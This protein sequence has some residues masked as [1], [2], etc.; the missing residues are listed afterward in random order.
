MAG[1]WNRLTTATDTLGEL[2][3]D[4]R[5]NRL[6]TER[7]TTASSPRL[8]TTEPPTSSTTS[9]SSTTDPSTPPRPKTKPLG[10]IPINYTIVKGDTL[11]NVAIRWRMSKRE[12]CDINHMHGGHHKLMHGQV[13]LVKPIAQLDLDAET[14]NRLQ[15]NSSST[16]SSSTSLN[17]NQPS[18]PIPSLFHQEP[19][20]ERVYFCTPNNHKIA[21]F[22]TMSYQLL[23]F[24]P[25]ADDP[26]V[27]NTKNGL[28]KF[29]FLMDVRDLIGSCEISH[30]ITGTTAT[31]AATTSPRESYE[32]D[33]NTNLVEVDD[34]ED[35]DDRTNASSHKGPMEWSMFQ[36]FWA[37]NGGGANGSLAR[38]RFYI[39]FMVPK[40]SIEQLLDTMRVYIEHHKLNG[41]NRSKH[42]P[43]LT[44]G[45][46]T[47]LRRSVSMSPEP[48]MGPRWLP[49]DNSAP[50]G[51]LEREEREKKSSGNGNSNSRRN[52]KNEGS[53]VNS[54]GGSSGGSGSGEIEK[55]KKTQMEEES[56]IDVAR[57]SISYG[58]GVHVPKVIGGTS[59][60]LDSDDRINIAAGL[61]FDS[62]DYNWQL[63]YSSNVHG[64]SWHTLHRCIANTGPNIVVVR[65]T[66]GEVMG[67]YATQSWV[68]NNK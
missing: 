31:A 40:D 24:E 41:D 32:E 26:I 52:S 19:V 51:V 29:Q 67:G 68:A 25:D 65:T 45:A 13:L 35:D 14:F 28:L 64:L 57:D 5:L 63:E 38:D 20:K 53:K 46:V 21:G 34:G 18:S 59:R 58:G 49:Q 61:P 11:A 6:T 62:R 27:K 3:F 30:T 10:Y 15:S 39:L 36:V 22:L 50:V 56:N 33:A 54:N 8:S 2:V 12:L 23:I 44:G 9:T 66:E 42:G 7:V 16:S 47:M 55:E 48:T 37:E 4:N 43:N 17:L 1:F 60:I